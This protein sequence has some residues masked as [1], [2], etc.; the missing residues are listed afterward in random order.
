MLNFLI[1]NI[2]LNVWTYAIYSFKIMWFYF[3]NFSSEK[4][5]MQHCKTRIFLY[6]IITGTYL[7]LG[8][9]LDHSWH[10]SKH[11]G[12]QLSHQHSVTSEAQSSLSSPLSS[13]CQGTAVL[14]D[15][16]VAWS[17]LYKLTIIPTGLAMFLFSALL[18]CS[19]KLCKIKQE[20]E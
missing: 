11:T 20:P 3:I 7:S 14:R 1:A 4:K 17:L 6:S 19:K 12:N 18:T 2:L 9:H 16:R 13:I 15:N 8:N 5:L 10:L